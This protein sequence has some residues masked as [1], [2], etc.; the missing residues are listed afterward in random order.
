[1]TEVQL[2][3]DMNQ[4]EQQLEGM[5]RIQQVSS[6]QQES[7]ALAQTLL[8]RDEK[9]AEEKR[10]EEETAKLWAGVSREFVQQLS[11]SLQET[12][13]HFSRVLRELT[14]QQRDEAKKPLAS[15]LREEHARQLQ[16]ITSVFRQSL[17]WQLVG[18][19]KQLLESRAEEER[20]RHLALLSQDR[21]G[22]PNDSDY[23]ADFEDV[24]QESNRS[25][26][27]SPEEVGEEGEEEEETVNL[28]DE[29]NISRP[30]S[31]VGEE[32]NLNHSQDFASSSI[33]DLEK[34]GRRSQ[35][36]SSE[37]GGA[38]G[39]T[40]MTRRAGG[41][42][43]EKLLER[44]HVCRAPHVI[45]EG[46][47]V[48]NAVDESVEETR[49][50]EEENEEGSFNA[51]VSFSEKYSEDFEAETSLRSR[52]ASHLS[53]K[54][55]A[56]GIAPQSLLP[57]P[58]PQPDVALARS[59]MRE[60]KSALGDANIPAILREDLVTRQAVAAF[61]QSLAEEESRCERQVS[62]LKLQEETLDEHAVAQLERTRAL[63]R[64]ATR[65]GS[66]SKMMRLE[67]EEQ[68]LRMKLAADK[69]ELNRLR[70]CSRADL[71]KRR[72]EL[73][74]Q[75][76]SFLVARK[77]TVMMR[78]GKHDSRE[79]KEEEDRAVGVA[80]EEQV[81]ERS[82]REESVDATL[83]DASFS[84]D[85]VDS[86]SS[87]H[88]PHLHH[89]QTRDSRQELHADSLRFLAAQLHLIDSA[90]ETRSLE[91]REEQAREKRQYAQKLLEEKEALAHM[92]RREMAVEAEEQR[93]EKLLEHALRYDVD[94]EAKKDV[95][96][97]LDE[98]WA[99]PSQQPGT[100]SSL[101]APGLGRGDSEGPSEE[102]EAKISSADSSRSAESGTGAGDD[103]G[104][105]FVRT[106]YD[107][108]S[109]AT[110]ELNQSMS[111]D[112]SDMEERSRT[113]VSD[114]IEDDT[115]LRSP[116]EREM[117]E[118]SSVATD[119]SQRDWEA[120][121]SRV[122]SVIEDYTQDFEE[123]ATSRNVSSSIAL[124]VM[125]E[126]Q[127]VEAGQESMS[128]VEE[129][130]AS[131]GL[132][133][134]GAAPV[135]Q[136]SDRPSRKGEEGSERSG[137]AAESFAYSLEFHSDV[138]EVVPSLRAESVSAD[139]VLEEELPSRSAGLTASL[140]IEEKRQG[141]EDEA[142]VKTR[143]QPQHASTG[144]E[145]LI[146]EGRGDSTLASVAYSDSF[147]DEGE[148][149]REATQGRGTSAGVSQQADEDSG[150]GGGTKVDESLASEVSERLEEESQDE[151]RAA[152]AGESSSRDEDTKVRAAGQNLTSQ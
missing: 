70:A 34:S 69:A 35:V 5:V 78:R 126:E 39:R 129:Q 143:E 92:R 141:E 80:K 147:I 128:E 132:A 74:M 3:E 134:D 84:S 28:P 9:L 36:T 138:E 124:V 32:E 88:I 43:V 87:G 60:S 77:D 93:T 51:P 16:E 59:A 118:A 33:E 111:S 24:E 119:M 65:E 58:S 29:I 148:E 125:E 26:S 71:W 150:R 21:E 45:E 149:E 79:D 10:R 146:E 116:K 115:N 97:L 17:T 38:A 14:A 19:E 104:G 13:D 107:P 72:M 57:P 133:S 41:E 136:E 52:D 46:S 108:F 31:I 64:S 62:L 82:R 75:L 53:S 151:R 44:P 67:Q 127:V 40:A 20:R 86:V 61:H 50:R 48:G 56:I 76:E 95:R 110:S 130:M 135:L 49:G 68:K 100:P 2:L 37:S 23:T 123:G 63:Y 139:D 142:A 99:R 122:A 66:R 73:R 145:S 12:T 7:V 22:S 83:S 85:G 117:G 105:L 144:S 54:V 89:P 91:E 27:R 8:M 30:P 137:H 101:V 90:A 96:L 42:Q 25:M 94:E 98:S 18:Q 109:A 102:D 11:Q 103:G 121:E 81:Q 131:Q 140:E 15:E 6:A 47:V 1:M 112:E 4:Y 55:G 113:E 106:A 114:S 120:A 152:G